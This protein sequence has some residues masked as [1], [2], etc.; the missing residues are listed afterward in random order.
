MI[1]NTTQETGWENEND[2]YDLDN[3]N[4][5]HMD[6]IAEQLNISKNLL[7][8]LSVKYAVAPALEIDLDPDQECKES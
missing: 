1:I 8:R 2:R 3:A 4:E 6:L 5:E 7:C